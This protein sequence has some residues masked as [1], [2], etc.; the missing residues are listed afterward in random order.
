MMPVVMTSPMGFDRPNIVVGENLYHFLGLGSISGYYA[1]EQLAY[2]PQ[3]AAEELQTSCVWPQ[4][5]DENGRFLLD[6]L[7]N[8]FQLRLWHDVRLQLARLQ[9]QYL[10]MLH[11]AEVDEGERNHYIGLTESVAREFSQL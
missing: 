9:Q 7:R 8:E 3:Q 6:L 5:L 2:N 1:L 10:P 4:L 11:F